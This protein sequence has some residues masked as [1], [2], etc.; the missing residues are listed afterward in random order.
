DSRSTTMSTDRLAA[1]RERRDH[2]FNH[3]DHSPL[4]DGQRAGFAGLSYFPYN[5]AL[6]LELP[7]QTDGPGIGER[8]RLATSD[9]QAKPFVRA[10]RITFE[11][12]GQPVTLS[13]FKDVERGRFYLPFRDGTAGRET[14][15]VGRYLDPRARPDGTLVVDFN[16]TY[17]PYCAYS[18][19]WSCPIPP[20]ENVTP[21]R[22][23][24]GERVYPDQETEPV[25]SVAADHVHQ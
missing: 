10:G 8:L 23:E 24:A 13:V 17:N 1:Y 6:V 16:Y 7:L 12:N 25:V 9:G 21:V 22:I 20:A 2:F 15:A 18:E 3:D 14:Y 19:G 4:D 5:P 11:V